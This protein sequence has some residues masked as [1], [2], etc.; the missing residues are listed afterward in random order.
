MLDGVNVALGVTGSIAAVRTV[1]LVHELQ[2]WGAEI[3]AV[4]TDGARGIV[5]PWALEF[6]TGSAP[7]TELTGAVEHVEL[8]GRDGWADVLLIAPATA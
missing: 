6:A 5:H 2:R 1:E 3:R 8:C 7:V 4:M